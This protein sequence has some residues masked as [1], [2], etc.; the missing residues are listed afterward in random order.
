M[1]AETLSKVIIEG[2]RLTFKTK[3][4]FGLNEHPP[5]VVGFRRYRYHSPLISAEWC[6]FTNVPVGEV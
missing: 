3:I 5:R 4:A 6:E 1:G 2:N